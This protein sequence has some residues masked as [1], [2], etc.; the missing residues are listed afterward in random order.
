MHDRGGHGEAQ[1][2]AGEAEDD[3]LGEQLAD[4]LAAARAAARSRARATGR[5]RWRTPSAA[6]VGFSDEVEHRFRTKLN[7]DSG[8]LNTDSGM[9]NTDFGHR[10]RSSVA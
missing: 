9:L 5:P 3:A 6:P 7:T 2:T 10:E 4:N 1:R 8:M